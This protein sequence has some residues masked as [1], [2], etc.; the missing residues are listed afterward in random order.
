MGTTSKLRREIEADIYNMLDDADPSG[1]NTTRMKNLFTKM[2]DKEF[3]QYMDEFYNNPDKNYVVSYKPFDNPITVEFIE[4]LMDKYGIPLYEYVYKPFLNGDTEDPPRTVYK[5]LVVDVPVKRLKQMVQVKNH[6]AVNPTKID[7]R[8]GQ[9]TGH[10][11]VARITQPELYSLIAQNQYN[12]AKEFFGPMADD[13]KAQNEMERIIQKDG[14][15]HL[16]DLSDDP[17]DHI[18]LNTIAYY[19]YGAALVTNML[20]Q[21]GYVLP[22]TQEAKEEKSST[23]RRKDVE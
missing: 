2:S 22:I 11:R 8:T 18:S 6:A 23:I 7:P 15:V 13:I 16:S 1:L 17:V 14:E 19:L 10:D 12:A 9:T 3:F 4:D 20:D 5:Q 21:S